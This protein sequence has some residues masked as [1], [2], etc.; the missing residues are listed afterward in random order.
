MRSPVPQLRIIVPEAD[1]AKPDEPARIQGR[2]PEPAHRPT[3]P[4]PLRPRPPKASRGAGNR[5]PRDGLQPYRKAVES[6][7]ELRLDPSAALVP[8]SDALPHYFPTH[9]K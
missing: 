9:D 3:L 5:G 4:A 7:G 8:S 6:S 2:V 1:S